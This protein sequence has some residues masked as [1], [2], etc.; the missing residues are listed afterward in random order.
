ML[1]GD[2][3]TPVSQR[4]T[5]RT[6]PIFVSTYSL[7]QHWAEPDYGLSAGQHAVLSEGKGT[8]SRR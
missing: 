4:W 7:V 1:Q 3:V 6:V 2:K 8:Y 5:D